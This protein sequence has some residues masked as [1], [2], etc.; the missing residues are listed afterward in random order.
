M[1]AVPSG[2]SEW[3]L[4]KASG[5]SPTPS[6]DPFRSVPFR[7]VPL[8][9]FRIFR[10]LPLFLKGPLVAPSGVGSTISKGHEMPCPPLLATPSASFQIIMLRRHVLHHVLSVLLTKTKPTFHRISRVTRI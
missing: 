7:S 9:S 2:V 10:L 5:P 1:L 6:S 8:P 3:R 4:R